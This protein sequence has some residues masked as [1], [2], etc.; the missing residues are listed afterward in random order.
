MEL[1]R[2]AWVQLLAGLSV[3]SGCHYLVGIT[4]SG[5]LDGG[6]RDSGNRDAAGEEAGVVP[7]QDAARDS[8][9]DGASDAGGEG[10]NGIDARDSV[11]N[12]GPW[13]GTTAF[14]HISAAANRTC[15]VKIVDG[16]I[17]CW[18]QAGGA[19]PAGAFQQVSAG[20]GHTCGLG[21][22]GTVVC[23]G[24]NTF[25]QT[26]APAGPYAEIT[27][28]DSH[29]CG[30]RMDGVVV[31][32]GD[33]RFGQGTAPPGNF[34]QISAGGDR[35]C[36]V[37]FDYAVNCRGAGITGQVKTESKFT[38]AST[39]TTLGCGLRQDT[40]AI[41]CWDNAGM[42]VSS[43]TKTGSFRQVSTGLAHVCGLMADGTVGCWGNDA[44]G[45]APPP[46]GSF[47]QVTTGHAH[48]CAIN[49]V[50]R[51]VVCWGDNTHGQAVPP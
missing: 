46:A 22:N 35:T 5:T 40:A 19:T 28:G 32:W 1:E 51:V 34:A 33:D 3:L 17:V 42:N 4:G 50:G 2:L 27:A 21:A 31:C 45:T 18:G 48:A 23:A 41:T 26:N 37:G 44:A 49:V 20:G 25:G 16:S 7:P 13:V 15:G 9:A 6:S 29:A 47:S 24:A 8:A 30:I 39:G 38:R 36:V 14:L 43:P 10:G 11:A 12:P